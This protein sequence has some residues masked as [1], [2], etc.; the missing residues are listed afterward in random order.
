MG[1]A[2]MRTTQTVW[3]TFS[4]KE[5]ATLDLTGKESRELND[6]IL[7]IVEQSLDGGD[8][9]DSELDDGFEDNEHLT[10]EYEYSFDCRFCIAVGGHYDYD[11][12]SKYDRYGDPGD[13]PSEEWDPEEGWIDSVDKSRVISDLV[14]LDKLG[15]LIDK[16]SISII[17]RDYDEDGELNVND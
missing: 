16:E 12:G 7:E 13:P 8:V 1:W 5:G 3:L 17:L 2:T 6:S 10:D 4:L 15:P 14:A 9:T 11:P